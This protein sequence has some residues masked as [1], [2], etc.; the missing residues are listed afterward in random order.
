[1]AHKPVVTP[2][3]DRD[4]GSW[5]YVFHDPD[6]MKGAIVDPVLDYDPDHARTATGNADRLLDFVRAEGIEVAWILDTHPHADHFSAGVYLADKLGAPRG[7]GENVVKVQ[8]LWKDLYNLPD[9]FPTDGRQWDRLFA[10]GDEFAVGDI[11]V[12]VLFTPGHTMAT[13]TYVA[14]DAA[15]ANDTFMMPENGTARAD[16][17]G[18]SSSELYD[19]LQRLLDLPEDTRIFIGHNYPDAGEA[20]RCEASVAE[21]KAKN[22]H[23]SGRDKAEYMELRD[24]RD[25]TLGLPRRMLAALQVNI[26]GGRLPEPKG[27][28][29]SY[30]TIPVNRF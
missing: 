9:D 17:P 7:I 23:L 12:R 28:G 21:H 16:F 6:T 22:A 13:V 15:F 8:R 24:A 2:F 26:R 29:V 19:S 25:A 5:Q 27:N 1:M 11:P 20:P 14:G 30:L 18:G 3:W 4:T 10:D